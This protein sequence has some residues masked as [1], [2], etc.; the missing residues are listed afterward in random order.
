MHQW[1]WGRPIRDIGPDF[2]ELPLGVKTPYRDSWFMGKV[3]T[4]MFELPSSDS[5][6]S[7]DTAIKGSFLTLTAFVDPQLTLS[8][9][10]ECRVIDRNLEEVDRNDNIVYRED[11]Y[12]CR[13][14]AGQNYSQERLAA[15][16][17]ER[18][19]PPQYIETN[20]STPAYH[21][22]RGEWFRASHAIDRRHAEFV[23]YEPSQGNRRKGTCIITGQPGIGMSFF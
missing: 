2:N 3:G 9:C 22:A 5:K 7:E 13:H 17:D 6:D 11:E 4:S 21:L 16:D 20:V 15:L 19:F 14:I 18:T 12:I 1:F 10:E 23:C 8:I